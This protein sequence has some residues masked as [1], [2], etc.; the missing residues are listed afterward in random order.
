[1]KDHFTPAD[2]AILV[3]DHQDF[4][5]KLALGMHEDKIRKRLVEV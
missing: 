1:M 3:I 5:I 2:S 4:A